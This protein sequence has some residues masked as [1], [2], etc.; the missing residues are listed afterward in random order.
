MAALVRTQLPLRY[1]WAHR[2]KIFGQSKMNTNYRLSYSSYSSLLW[3]RSWFSQG[4]T[5]SLITCV[6]V[7]CRNG[8]PHGVWFPELC[9]FGQTIWQGFDLCIF[10]RRTISCSRLWQYFL[11]IWQKNWSIL[12]RDSLVF[13]FGSCRIRLP[14]VERKKI[15]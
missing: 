6:C 2:A 9:G 3:F 7:W 12:R 15:K 8:M 10:C 5:F 4:T 11:T 14:N 13:T 1:Y